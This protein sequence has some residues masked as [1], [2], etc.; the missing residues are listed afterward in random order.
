MRESGKAYPMWVKVDLAAL[1]EAAETAPEEKPAG[2]RDLS[3]VTDP[4][5]YREHIRSQLEYLKALH[6][7]G[8]ISDSEYDQKR[9]A[10]IDKI[11]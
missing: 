6:D 3:P 9:K 1:R 8:L 10:L 2:E 11:E 7:D 4:E 5:E